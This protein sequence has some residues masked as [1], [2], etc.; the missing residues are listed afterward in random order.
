MYASA[1][2]TCHSYHH[3]TAGEPRDLLPQPMII[4]TNY[5]SLISYSCFTI[6]TPATRS[7]SINRLPCHERSES[8]ESGREPA[9]HSM[10]QQTNDLFALASNN[11]TSKFEPSNPNASPTMIAN[12]N[13][14]SESG[15]ARLL[16]RANNSITNTGTR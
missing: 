10:G 8:G 13:S 1:L 11:R 6:L 16:P 5:Q 14:I 12:S 2:S 9:V 3:T 7:G 4:Q 15:A